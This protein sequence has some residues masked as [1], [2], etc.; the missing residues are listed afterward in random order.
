MTTEITTEQ[1]INKQETITEPTE[2]TMPYKACILN[3]ARRRPQID[4]CVTLRG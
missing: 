2:F 3:Q 4:R 1:R